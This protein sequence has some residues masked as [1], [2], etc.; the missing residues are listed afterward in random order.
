MVAAAGVLGLA[1]V[2]ALV[3]LVAGGDD[4]GDD[5]ASDTAVSAT[6][7]TRAERGATTNAPP[8]STTASTA[9][10]PASTE[11][12]RLVPGC[13]ARECAVLDRVDDLPSAAGPATVALVATGPGE[14]ETRFRVVVVAAGGERLWLSAEEPSAASRDGRLLADPLVRDRSGNVLGAYDVGAHGG[15]VLVV[16]VTPQ[17]IT[18]V[19]SID[20]LRFLSDSPPEVT[21]EAGDGILEIVTSVN[22]HDPSYAGG[23]N[24]FTT[25]GWNGSDYVAVACRSVRGD[26]PEARHAPVGGRCAPEG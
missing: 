13:E 5:R 19:G 4:D 21:D 14:Y 20:D 25:Y 7:T 10:P 16:R 2:V 9:P 22:D 17:G 6:S 12:A 11:V 3:A 18:D 23:I 26:G 15:F 1:V 24:T 8:T